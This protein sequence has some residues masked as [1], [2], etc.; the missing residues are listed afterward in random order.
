[1]RKFAIGCV[2]ALVL[3]V[4]SCAALLYKS[5][6]YKP[7][8][9]VRVKTIAEFETPEGLKSFEAVNDIVVVWTPELGIDRTEHP[10][11]DYDWWDCRF[12][13]DGQALVARPGDRTLFLIKGNNIGNGGYVK[14]VLEALTRRTLKNCDDAYRAASEVDG[15]FGTRR[16]ELP[17]RD[18]PAIVSFTD[19]GDR[20][21]GIRIQPDEAK[22]KRVMVETSWS[23]LSR[24]IEETL[25]WLRTPESYEKN[26]EN[27]LV[28]R[29]K[30]YSR[31]PQTI[32]ETL[33][34]DNFWEDP[35]ERRP[36][37]EEYERRES[38]AREQWV[39]SNRRQRES[40]EAAEKLADP[41]RR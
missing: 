6:L 15:W 20:S 34:F 4:G 17:A 41:Q 32:S 18:W 33:T 26:R 14:R 11:N 21:T 12:R 19:L 24:G 2:L 28:P 22:L 39:E 23:P 29:P 30:D 40:R 8:N 38:A 16:A 35:P 37:R 7:D 36:G 25:D 3:L 13:L 27:F 10:G 5:G 1:M 31:G 9:K